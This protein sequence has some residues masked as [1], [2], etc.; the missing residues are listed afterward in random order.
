MSM[1]EKKTAIGRP[2]PV[3]RPPR[4]A[5]AFVLPATPATYNAPDK[6]VK[7]PAKCQQSSH[8]LPQM[9]DALDNHL[10]VKL[11]LFNYEIR[12]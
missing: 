12:A 2:P 6:T 1:S 5:A 8:I 10:W 9:I 3:S 4:P 11:H 7:F